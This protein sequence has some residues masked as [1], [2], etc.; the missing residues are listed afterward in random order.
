MK[1]HFFDEIISY[2]YD[3]FTFVKKIFASCKSIDENT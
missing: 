3:G 1:L 2:G